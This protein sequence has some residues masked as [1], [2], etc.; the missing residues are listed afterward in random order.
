LNLAVAVTR[1]VIGANV[2]GANSPDDD[3]VDGA[4][5]LVSKTSSGCTT[6]SWDECNDD[7]S[8]VMVDNDN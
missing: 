1:V 2:D 3:D 4:F 5:K 6:I 7:G 8:S